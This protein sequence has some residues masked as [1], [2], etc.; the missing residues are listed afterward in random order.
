[1]TT[2]LT[3]TGISLQINTGREHKTKTPTDDQMRQYLRMEP[4]LAS[5]EAKSL[6]QIIQS[7]DDQL[8]FLHTAEAQKC[9]SLLQE[10]F[11]NKG[12]K[13]VRLLP[14]EFQGDERQIEMTG[15]RNLVNALIDEVEKAQHKDANVVINA[16]AG[17]KAQVV[18]STMIGMLYNVPVKYIHESFQRI[19]TFNPIALEWDTSLFLTYSWFFKWLDGESIARKQIEV[20]QRLKAIPDKEAIEAL[21]TPPDDDGEVFLSPMGNA[22]ERRF[23]QESEEAENVAWPSAAKEQNIEKKIAASLLGEK[24]HFLHDLLPVCYKIAALDCVEEV[25]GGHFENAALTRIKKAYDDGTI[26]MLWLNNNV[27]ARLTIRT[28][29]QGKL[30]TLKVAEKIKEILGIE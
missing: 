29:A 17:F 8:V 24:H 25:I 12:H 14:L 19:V 18:Y 9:A 4:T 7:D 13:H 21:L 28:T 23:K 20:E 27:G 15:I 22:L 2:I 16:T 6:M 10:F 30:Q 1:M 26:L 5:S 11:V 3:T